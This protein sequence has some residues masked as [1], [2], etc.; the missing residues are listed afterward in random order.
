MSNNQTREWLHS[1]EEAFYLATK[2]EK[3]NKI[4]EELR[5][6]DM[7][8]FNNFADELEADLL[9][10]CDLCGK[11]ADRCKCD[12]EYQQAKDDKLMDEYEHR[13]L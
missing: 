10:T 6:Y 5:S 2:P 13:T 1:M 9:S 8:E 7:T 3:Q 4:L 12:D 11:S